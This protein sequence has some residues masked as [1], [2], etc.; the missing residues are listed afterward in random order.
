[1]APQD[2]KSAPR[3]AEKT[4]PPSG[5]FV[6]DKPRGPT[7]HDVVAALRRKLGTR[8]I[9]HAGTLDPMAT[10][11]LV[12]AIGEAT[13]LSPYLTAADKRYEATLALG[14]ATDTLD[15][16]GRETSRA[17]VPD[18]VRAALERLRAGD[19]PPELLAA[20]DLELA[21]TSQIP[22]VYSAIKQG[23]EASHARARR[24]DATELP[25][26]AVRA[27]AIELRGGG[28]APSPWLAVSLHVSKGYYVRAFA[29][30]LAAA[31]GTCGHLSA[32]C[33]TASG[34]FT[35]AEALP[36]DTPGDELLARI[37][38]LARAAARALPSL[39]LSDLAVR[40]A[41]FGRA[42][43]LVGP[44]DEGAEI[45]GGPCAWLDERGALVAIG[46]QTSAGVGRV[47]RGFSAAP[48]PA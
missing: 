46:E 27:H 4:A 45:A 36:F 3:L 38:P 35:L 11:V 28:A 32:L 16:E 42:V 19:A 1:M 30:D 13:K 14:V 17:A 34:E 8:E 29:R 10:G 12:V 7:S 23:G 25:P 6:L 40:E 21:R 20:R 44:G 22:P 31:L 33:R 26:R 48:Q 9:G 15:A 41:R 39:V 37:V 47:L 24:G 18:A 5:V 43:P 2:R